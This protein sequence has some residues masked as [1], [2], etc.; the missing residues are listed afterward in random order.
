MS[1]MGKAADKQVSQMKYSVLMSVYAKDKPE[2]LFEA[3]NS[4]LTQTVPP[5]QFVIVID[6]PVLDELLQP[7]YEYQR[8]YVDLFTIVPLEKNGGLGNALN[9]GLKHCRNEL[10]ARMDADD[11][12]LP[13][14]CE[15]ELAC[16]CEDETLDIC[17]CNIDEFEGEPE[18]VLTSRVVP[19]GYEQIKRFMRR[20]Q[21]FN[22]A[23]VIYRKTAVFR[24]GGYKTLKRKED[25]DL[26]SRMLTQGSYAKNLESSLYLC[27]VDRNG[28]RR[29]KSWDNLKS[30]IFVYW[31]HLRRKGCTVADFLLLC[32]AETFFLVLPDSIM[33][34]ISDNFLRSKACK[35]DVQTSA[36]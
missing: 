18:N 7:V 16:F 12:S 36:K 27:R 1:E 13:E 5:E 2:Y 14:R 30:A 15:K 21:A 17:G 4:M 35:D 31:R 10:V 22:H 8:Y 23:T 3:V 34:W 33:K 9:E 19:S 32:G 26:F 6:G 20:R 28:Y 11:I 29:R 25:F 24:A